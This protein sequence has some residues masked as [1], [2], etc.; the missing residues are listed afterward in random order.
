MSDV[1]VE[2]KFTYQGVPTNTEVEFQHHYGKCPLASDHVHS[3]IEM[4]YCVKGEYRAVLG[5]ETEY[6]FSKGDLLVINSWEVHR[7]YCESELDAAQWV[8][9]LEPEILYN[10]T[11]SVFEAQYA[12]PFLFQDYKHPRLL[13]AGELAESIVPTCLKEICRESQEQ[14]YGFELAIRAALCRIFTWILRHWN[15][16]D[17]LFSNKTCPSKMGTHNLQKTLSYVEEHYAEPIEVADMA[18]LCNLSYSYFSHQFR[19]SIGTTFSEYLNARRIAEAERLLGTTD[20]TISEIALQV[21]YSNPGYFIQK[22]KAQK[23]VSPR[24]FREIY[25]TQKEK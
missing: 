14:S 21:G 23:G 16:N 18:R 24:K 20:A 9:K 4:L 12:L 1:W 22:F 19:Q 3:K 7:N 17:L 8:I 25:L 2:K 6:R 10:T 15:Q 13:K 11:C 5:G